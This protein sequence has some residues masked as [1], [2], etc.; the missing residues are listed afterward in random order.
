MIK[1]GSNLEVFIVEQ[2]G[3]VLWVISVLF[4]R[5]PPTKP[6]L[7]AP[8][9]TVTPYVESVRAIEPARAAILNKYNKTKQ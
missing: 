1:K 4:S 5:Y 9:A 6:P 7:S 8:G 2:G 3:A